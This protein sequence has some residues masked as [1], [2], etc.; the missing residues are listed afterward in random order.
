MG[1]NWTV[2]AI[3]YATVELEGSH[4]G[5]NADLH[6]QPGILDYFVWVAR[7]DTHTVLIDTGFEEKEGIRR[8]RSFIEDPIAGLGRLGIAPPDITDIVITHL[9]YDHAGNLDKYPN[10][11]LHLQDREMSYATGRCMCHERFRRAF[12]VEDVVK[13][14]RLL[15][16]GRIV[17][18][19]G[20]YNLLPGLDVHLIGGHS[21]GL[22][23]PVFRCAG[24]PL[25][26]ASDAL[27]LSRYLE[28]DDVF[29]IFGNAMEV[30][31]GYRTLKQLAGTEGV[32]VSGH[33]PCVRDDFPE[34]PGIGG[35]IHLLSH[36]ASEHPKKRKARK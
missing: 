23:I 27:H 28:D 17:F 16:Q 2:H 4:F 30:L 33:D 18:H 25:V 1:D 11:R 21:L 35:E 3:R 8:G 22:Q 24:R 9:H 20:G 5:L 10:A 7:S 29:P 15:Y 34:V 31:E 13:A 14:V 12:S 19:E 6:D 26:L 36:W 32:I